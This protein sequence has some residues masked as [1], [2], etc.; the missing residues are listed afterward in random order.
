MKYKNGWS[1][2]DKDKFN[3]GET[4]WVVYM[5]ATNKGNKIVHR[6]GVSQYTCTKAEKN[7]VT[8]DKPFSKDRLGYW[9][10]NTEFKHI[11]GTKINNDYA[12]LN[13]YG[14]AICYFFNTEQDARNAHDEWIKDIAE[15][16]SVVDKNRMYAH[17]F[18]TR[19]DAPTEEVK[20]MAFYNSLNDSDK[21]HVQ[22]LKENGNI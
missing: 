10:G 22:W 7:W 20:A 18:G 12:Y 14:I 4:Y 16:N 9:S 19:P 13:G 11:S 21:A 2:Y 8:F 15:G 1:S 5:E 3:V 17:L 6:N